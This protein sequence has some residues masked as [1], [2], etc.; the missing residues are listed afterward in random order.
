MQFLFKKT[1]EL[2]LKIDNFINL[3]REASLH[4]QRTLF[5][6]LD[7][8]IDD[9]E[10]KLALI[11]ETESRAD[12]IKKDIEGKL[13]V[14]TLIPESRGDV[15]GILET[16][17]RIIDSTKST[18]MGFSIEK[19][20]VPEQITQGLKELSE[21][22]DKAVESL[23]AAVRSYFQDVSAVKDYLHLVKFYEKDADTLS[24]K[25][26]RD[27]FSMNIYLSNKLQLRDFTDKIDGLADEAL[28]VA[29]RVNIAAIKRIV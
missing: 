17:D 6:F 26:K 9:F 16:M 20:V 29:E 24:E 12:S 1:D 2:I 27:I 22:V 11:T 14:Q 23:A 10:K 19:P 28:N 7:G 3:T 13:Y 21:P 8:R 15:L 5:L 18:M 25:I 4:F